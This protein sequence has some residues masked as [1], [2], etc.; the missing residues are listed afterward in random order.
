MLF[1]HEMVDLTFKWNPT[2]LELASAF[3]EM[4][5]DGQAKFFVECARIAG[6]WT[7]AYAGMQW[8]LVGRHLRDCECSTE[9]ARDMVKEICE[10]IGNSE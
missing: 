3:C 6:T 1:E 7:S 4:D 8:H 5:D 10:G 9:E 2:P